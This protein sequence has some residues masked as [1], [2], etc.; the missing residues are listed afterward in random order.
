MFKHSPHSKANELIL[1]FSGNL[2]FC[3]SFLKVFYLVLR[4]RAGEGKRERETQN[5]KQTPSFE[6][7]QPD[8]GL[9]P[10]NSEI[11]TWAEVRC[12]TDWAT[13]VPLLL[14]IFKPYLTGVDFYVCCKVRFALYCCGWYVWRKSSLTQV[15]SWQ[16]EE[17]FNSLFR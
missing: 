14:F 4:E 16:K 15:S 17:N 3:F 10:K 7:S 6:L 9:E 2:L 13:Q 8:E 5:L 12:L 1:W 11:I